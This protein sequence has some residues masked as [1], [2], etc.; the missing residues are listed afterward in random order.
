[1][2]CSDAKVT[3]FCPTSIILGAVLYESP[4]LLYQ[5]IQVTPCCWLLAVGRW[6][7]DFMFI[8]A[9]FLCRWANKLTKKTKITSFHFFFVLLPMKQ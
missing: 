1:M 2:I 3:Q 8:I 9:H 5:I 6:L 4:F 7:L